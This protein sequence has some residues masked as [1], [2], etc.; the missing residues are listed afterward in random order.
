M[1][2]MTNLDWCDVSYFR[3]S[4]FKFPNEINRFLVFRLDEFRKL[5]K[6]PIIIHS[7]L[8]PGDK[9]THGSGDAVDVHVEGIGLLDAYLLAEKSGLFNGIGVYPNWHNPG[10]HLDMRYGAPARWGC[11]SNKEPNIYVPLDSA[12]IKAMIEQ[13]KA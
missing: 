13:G 2:N 8:R 1:P 9:G 11:W 5:I 6:K 12:F 7:D 3:P 4:E 10:L